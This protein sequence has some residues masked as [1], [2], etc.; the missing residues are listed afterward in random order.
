METQ[1]SSEDWADT[2]FHWSPLTL[3]QSAIRTQTHTQTVK[4]WTD[5]QETYSAG[6]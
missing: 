5:V 6:G 4:L 2:A 1:W 3:S